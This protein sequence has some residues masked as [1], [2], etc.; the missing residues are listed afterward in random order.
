MPMNDVLERILN[1]DPMVAARMGI[2]EN[3]DP[4][5]EDPRAP[6][7]LP[8][9]P[10]DNSPEQQDRDF[11]VDFEHARDRMKVIVELGISATQQALALAESGDS[12]RAFEVVG[13]IMDSTVNA[14]K[15]LVNIHTERKKTQ[16][17]SGGEPRATVHVDRAVFVGTRSDLIRQTQQA[18]RANN[19]AADVID[20]TPTDITPTASSDAQHI[21]QIE[22]PH[23]T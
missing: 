12:P 8:P 4:I 1:V 7:A 16:P 20:I 9:P 15:E 3:N 10:L 18:A 23:A 11:E 17:S 19:A 5:E 22:A 2:E 21:P 13:K 6:R 14:S